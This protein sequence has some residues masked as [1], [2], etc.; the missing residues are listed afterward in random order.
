MA[1][2]TFPKKPTTYDEVLALVESSQGVRSFP[3][4]TLRDV[5]GAG[6]LGTIVVGSISK[7]LD[8][9]G[10]SHFPDPLPLNQLE[11]ARIYK[12]NSRVGELLQAAQAVDT[13]SNQILRRI[14]ESKADDALKRIR[15]IVC[16]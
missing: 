9:R 4:G 11:Y 15:D 13:K 8:Q 10:L 14:A 16:D 5:H 2:R 7:Q 1:V 3:M 12:R 6:K